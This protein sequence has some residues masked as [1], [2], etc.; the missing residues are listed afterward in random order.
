MSDLHTS[1]PADGTVATATAE[2]R[3]LL[4][5]LRQEGFTLIELL[6]VIS[7]LGIL[8]AITVFSVAGLGDRGQYAACSTDTVTIRTAQEAF[9]AQPAPAGGKYAA[10]VPALIAGGFLSTISTLHTSTSVTPFTSYS[11][12]LINAAGATSNACAKAAGLPI[13]AANAAVD[14]NNLL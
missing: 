4:R 7:I 10:D 14:G 11:I 6:V 3:N 2:G 5:R 9:Y 13:A 1:A 12:N 8:A